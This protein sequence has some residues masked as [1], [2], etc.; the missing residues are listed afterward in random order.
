MTQEM[1]RRKPLPST[2][3]VRVK[4]SI[5]EE[6]LIEALKQLA[7]NH[8]ALVAAQQEDVALKAKV[9]EL[10]Q[11]ANVQT[12]AH[13]AVTASVTRSQGRDTNVIDP[14][15]YHKLVTDDEFYG[16]ITVGVTKA[17]TVLTQTELAKVT[18]TKP[19]KLG[20][21]ELVIAYAV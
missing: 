9:Y 16:T 20:E 15:G 4:E 14:R 2:S 8:A 17:R 21:P 13:G 11:I 12:F 18:T 19:G 10:M 5:V 3:A 1:F 7:T 6:G